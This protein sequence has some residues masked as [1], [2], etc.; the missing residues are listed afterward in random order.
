VLAAV[1]GAIVIL[2]GTFMLGSSY[3]SQR[4]AL[5]VKVASQKRQLRSVHEML[6]QR[7]FWEQRAKWV[8]EKQPK[9]ENA[10]TAGVQLLEYVQTLAKKHSIVLEKL[11]IHSAERRPE[12]T[13]VSLDV[14]TKS[15]WAPLISFL[16]DLQAPEQFIAVESVNLK[17][18]GS[19]NTQMRG[20]LKIARWYAPN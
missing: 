9:L 17:Q 2:G 6:S 13:S 5:Q 18:D 14:E 4:A 11:D 1:V 10:D 19:D 3:L 8:Q 12:C 15:P 16:C 20:H 7:N